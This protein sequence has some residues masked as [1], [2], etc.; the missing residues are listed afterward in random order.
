MHNKGCPVRCWGLTVA[1]LLAGPAVFATDF[2]FDGEFTY[3]NDVALLDFTVGA[4][5]TVTVFTSSWIQGHPPFG[6]DPV[7]GLWDGMGNLL[8]VQDDADMTGTA[9]SNGV[10]Y[11]YGEWDVYFD[12]F[13]AAG[14]YQ[15]SLTQFDNDPLGI[16]LSAGFRR[17]G[18]PSF[19]TVWGD[20][21]YFNGIFD[22]TDNGI[23]DPEDPRSPHWA[24]HVINVA[25]AQTVPEPSTWLL[26][27]VGGLAI[28]RLRRRR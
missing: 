9:L 26:F 24:L 28:A 18:N 19:T 7:V 3:D 4:A 6:F 10:W 15:L 13:L 27:G 25:P 5:S 22:N 21:P 20:E 23:F 14:D 16:T 1:L 8:A 17:D 11:D 12:R 2:D